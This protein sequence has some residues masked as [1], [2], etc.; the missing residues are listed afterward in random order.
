M[1]ASPQLSMVKPVPYL[2][3][4]QNTK[5]SSLTGRLEVVVNE[6]FDE[7]LEALRA[8]NVDGSARG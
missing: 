2:A 3:A 8:E 7:R 1:R 5:G 6:E 4:L